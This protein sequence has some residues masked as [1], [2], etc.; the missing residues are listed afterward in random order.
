[1]WGPLIFSFQSN[2]FVFECLLVIQVLDMPYM[3]R[4]VVL[5]VLLKVDIQCIDSSSFQFRQKS[6]AQNMLIR[7]QVLSDVTVV[8]FPPTS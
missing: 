7:N 3:V 4:D 8:V 5:T 1:M 2:K 6:V